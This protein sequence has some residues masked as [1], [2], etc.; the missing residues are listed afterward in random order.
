MQHCSKTWGPS[1]SVEHNRKL[2][3]LS[4]GS[5][6][7][8]LHPLRPGKILWRITKRHFLVHQG[9]T[10]VF[11]FPSWAC[12]GI[13]SVIFESNK[14]HKMSIKPTTSGKC[15]GSCYI[16]SMPVSAQPQWHFLPR[17][18][19]IHDSGSSDFLCLWGAKETRM[20]A[21]WSA[22]VKTQSPVA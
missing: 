2:I 3:I 13:F 19:W 16:T 12:H 20:M 7:V 8:H 6:V 15:V 14:A 21:L 18:Y 17:Q 9:E 1:N 5:R 10:L 11:I 22:W 4:H